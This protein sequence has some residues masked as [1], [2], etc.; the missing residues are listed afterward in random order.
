MATVSGQ[1]TTANIGANQ[2]RIDL[3]GKILRLEPDASPLTVISR[4]MKSSRRSTNNRTFQ[5]AEQARL[6]RFDQ[7]NNGA[8]YAAGAT[9]IVV[10]DGTK[11]RAGTLVKVPR[12]GEVLE[13][14]G[15]STNTLTAV[16]GVGNSGTGVAIV[17]DDPLLILGTAAEEGGTALTAIANDPTFVTNYTQIFKRS[18]EISGSAASE[19]NVTSPHDWTLQHENE[20]MEHLLDMEDAFLFGKPDTTTLSINSKPT[21]TTGGV[22]HFA[23]QNGVAAGGTLTEAGFETFLRGVFRYGSK[24]K[25]LFA[26]PLLVSVL[27]A[28]SQNKLNTVVGAD[29]YGV[30]VMK[31][32]SPH[33]T[34]NIV[35]HNLLEGATYGGYG[36]LLDMG[37]GNVSYRYLDGGPGGSRDTKLLKDRQAPDRDGLLDEWLT[38]AGLQFGEAKCHGVLTGVTG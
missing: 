13:V 29:T 23:N 7:V 14:S 30:Q 38:E 31:W 22:L 33:G 1:R 36:I 17:D 18:V 25:T 16:R 3:T 12:T 21:Y 27:N 37:R 26:S 2:R 32:V 20:A 6:T 4:M 10:D 15:V 35:K 34:V 11:F 19:E 24:N 8:G 9:S 28:F 5:W